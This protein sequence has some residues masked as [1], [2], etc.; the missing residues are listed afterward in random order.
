M[1]TILLT[2]ILS[3]LT[4]AVF[5]QVISTNRNPVGLESNLLFNAQKR[6]TVTQTGTGLVSLPDLFDGN[7]S[8]A[9]SSAGIST[10]SPTVITI[11]GLSGWHTQAGAWVGWTTRYWPARRFKIE[12]YETYYNNNWIT[13]ADYSANDYSGGD[14]LTSLTGVFTQLRFTFYEGTGDG[15][16]F[17]LSEIYFIHPEATT[18][19][20]GLFPVFNSLS[21]VNNNILIGK[22]SQTNTAYKLDVGGKIRADEIVVNTTG[23]DFVFDSTYNLRS[24]LELETFIKQ[25][26]HLPEMPPAKEMQKN[27]VSAGEMQAKL[28]QKVEELTLYVIE[29]Q[30]TIDELKKENLLIKQSLNNK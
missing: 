2:V 20:M 7:F 14:F 12:G 26:K 25:N 19:Y 27:G 28:L 15:G 11:S 10:S 18:P 3:I 30:K 24:L 4:T 17:G 6:F 13:I 22:T 1:K 5:S 8:P 21:E 9:Y 29:Q 23:A 16:R